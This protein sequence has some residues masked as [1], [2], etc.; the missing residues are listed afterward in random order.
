MLK[1]NKNQDH[2]TDIKLNNLNDKQL[3]Y[4]IKAFKSYAIHSMFLENLSN[5][6]KK[7][8]NEDE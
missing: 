2:T 1:I 3:E 8:L 4:V 5:E 6:I 7:Q